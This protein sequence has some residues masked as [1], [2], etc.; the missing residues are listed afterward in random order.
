MT[1]ESELENMYSKRFERKEIKKPI[2]SATI[3]Q[4]HNNLLKLHESIT[5]NTP[6]LFGQMNWLDE[7]SAQDLLKIIRDLPGR[8]DSKLGI[9]AQRQ[10]LTSILVAI[11]VIDFY[12]G[13]DTQ[14]FKDISD[15]LQ[16]P[17]QKELDTYREKL[18]VETKESLSPYEDIMKITEKF[19]NTDQGD[20]DMKILLRIYTIYPIRLEAADL[21]YVEDHNKF[22]K[23]KKQPLTKNYVVIGKRKV[24]FSWSD[25]KTFNKY[26]TVE[27][28]I[29][30]KLLKKLLQQ[31]AVVAPNME[32][33]FNI[34]RNTLSKRISEFYKKN[35]Y[36]DVYPTTL[37]KV[38]ETH[39]YNSLPEEDRNKMKDLA[40]FRRH[41]LETQMKF[42]VHN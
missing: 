40:D 31:K 12:K 27:F 9:A 24:L 19:I 33:M 16:E 14:L 41:S 2:K 6:N 30:D 32:P 34:S 28:E 36:K 17:L 29:K 37:A 10:Y 20:L 18:K 39:A 4:H 22:R 13:Q 5:G 25:Y 26:G 42:Y 38:I 35:G 7:K 23:M 1:I 8:K 11:R 15:L 21:I 3:Y